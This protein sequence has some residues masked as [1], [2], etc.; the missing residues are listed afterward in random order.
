MNKNRYLLCLLL[1]GL[2][3]YFA[4]PRLS[5]LIESIEGIFSIV[6]LAFALIIVAGNMTALL[7]EPKKEKA[8]NKYNMKKMGGKRKVRQIQ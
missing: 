3:L 4:I 8:K 7:Y 6:W 1:C 2:M 5:V